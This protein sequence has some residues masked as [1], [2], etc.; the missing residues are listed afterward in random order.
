ME[1]TP[2]LEEQQKPYAQRRETVSLSNL[3]HEVKQRRVPTSE[4][5]KDYRR[6]VETPSGVSPTRS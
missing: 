4:E 1:D 6:Y 2:N 3:Q 5:M